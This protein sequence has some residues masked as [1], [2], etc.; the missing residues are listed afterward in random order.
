M[1]SLV[2][3]RR[4]VLNYSG[5]STYYPDLLPAIAL[6]RSVGAYVELVTV[7]S[8]LGDDMLKPLSESGLNRLTVSVH[9]TQPDLYSEIYRH[10]SFA[11]V[12]A[13]L[14][15]LLAH[16]RSVA[17]PPLV[18]LAFVA[19]DR[20]LTELPKVTA[21]AQSL[22]LGDV[23]IFPV[24]RRDPIPEAFL[25]EV[26]ATGGL[27]PDFRSRLVQELDTTRESYPDVR[28]TMCNPLLTA[29]PPCLGEVPISYPWPLPPGAAIHNCEQN[30]WETAHVLSNGDIVACEVSDRQPLGNLFEQSMEEIWNGPLYRRFREQYHGGGIPECRACVWK[31]AY[32]P[33]ELRPAIV[34]ARGD[35]PQLI[36]GWHAGEGDEHIWSTQRATAVL[37]SVADAGSLHV[38]GLLPP[39]SNGGTNE[40]EIRCAGDV[41]G[42][43][44]NPFAEMMPFGLDFPTPSPQPSPLP[45]EFRT[46]QVYRPSEQGTGADQ[47]DLGFALVL[48]ASKPKVDPELHARRR[49]A[50]R[51]LEERIR[52]ID[53]WARIIAHLSPPH[54]TVPPPAGNPGLSVLIPERDSV[55]SLETCLQSLQCAVS[56][57]AEPV[58]VIVVVNGTPTGAYDALQALHPQAEWQFHERPL[59]FSQ[60]VAS[61]LRLARHDWVYL[62]NNDTRLDPNALS[63]AAAHRDPGTFA[64]A[65]QIF[66]EDTTRF[67]EETNWCDLADENGLVTLA[68]RIPRSTQTVDSFYAG[69]GASLFQRQ[70]L[71]RFVD[72]EA[73]PDFYWEDVE[74][75]WRARKLGY[76][77][78]F[79]AGSVV[80]HTQGASVK[81][82]FSP[83][84]VEAMWARN[85]ALLQLRNW[86][87]AGQLDSVL[88][89]LASAPES[90]A[91][92]FQNSRTLSLIARGRLWNHRCAVSDEEVLGTWKRSISTC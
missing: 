69:G 14:E 87:T 76:R 42:V 68:D 6:A 75:G 80:H 64:I 35:N 74:W 85:R 22:G 11:A 40:L 12:A 28:L 5:E 15:S 73:Y 8:P 21:L 79:C 63:L 30:P 66:L 49:L 52:Q 19:M 23:L 37:A 55:A 48:L 91:Q 43:V 60:A 36:H 53:R 34:A 39:A 4:L 90:V 86:T 17:H 10:G 9:A 84:Q 45:I 44:T 88:E 78:L 7:L 62:L 81:R 54:R 51:P 13:K 89:F 3:P 56:H 41:V 61:G 24:M 65:S 20:N 77:I 31:T 32:V 27:R 2:D 58:Q 71:A 26:D 50:L 25:V 29:D 82:F 16:C 67:R 33:T 38:S 92:S 47:R 57:L 18:D 1:R 70:L 59:G 72:P 46:T 83:A